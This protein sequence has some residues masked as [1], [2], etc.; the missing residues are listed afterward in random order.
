M[1]E[2]WFI[3]FQ[4]KPLLKFLS[5][6]LPMVRETQCDEIIKIVFPTLAHRFQVMNLE[7]ATFIAT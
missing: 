3:T 7:P 5:V 1:T 2:E 6:L 4:M